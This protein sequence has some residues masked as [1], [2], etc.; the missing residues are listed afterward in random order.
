MDEID[1][2]IAALQAAW[3]QERNCRLEAD[4]H[5]DREAERQRALAKQA[6]LAKL[7]TAYAKERCDLIANA[8]IV[9]EEYLL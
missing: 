4:R 6:R 8:V 1:T 3:N 7:R 9:S 5:N 2:E